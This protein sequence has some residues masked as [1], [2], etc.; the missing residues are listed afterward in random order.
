MKITQTNTNNN[1]AANYNDDNDDIVS[2]RISNRKRIKAKLYDTDYMGNEEQL[3]LHQVSFNI[4]LI[5]NQCIRHIL[6][7]N[8]I[9]YLC[10]FVDIFLFILLKAIK[11][12]RLETKRS[13]HD[14]PYAPV[15][16][17]TVEEFKD[18]IQYISKYDCNQHF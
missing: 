13:A 2:K 5:R 10:F 15:F 6:L 7:L 17:P 11:V 16:Y 9:V 14:I 1:D 8:N 3:M 4:S 12:S 18:P